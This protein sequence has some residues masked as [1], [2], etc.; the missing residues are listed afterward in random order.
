MTGRFHMNK[1]FS[2]FFFENDSFWWRFGLSC[3]FITLALGLVL[4]LIYTG[5]HVPFLTTLD[6]RRSH[7]HLG[8]YGV[9]FPLIWSLLGRERLWVPRKKWAWAYVLAVAISVIGFAIEG[10]GISAHL[11][12]AVVLIF[13]ITF[14]IKNFHSFPLKNNWLSLIPTSLF[15]ATACVF[16]VGF[17][18]SQ[19]KT[20]ASTQLAR[21]FLTLL[22]FGVVIPVAIG[23]VCP[24][25]RF[26]KFWP[27]A[28]IGMAVFVSELLPPL[29]FF[30][31][32]L[33]LGGIILI[34]LFSSLSEAKIYS[35]LR[36]KL[37]WFL[38][39]LSLIVFSIG[40]IRNSHYG[41][42]AGVHFLVL[43][44]ILMSFVSLKGKLTRFSYDLSLAFM[45]ISI[46]A[47]EFYVADFILLQKIALL[48]GVVV[49]AILATAA[50][51]SFLRNSPD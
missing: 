43:G 45:V 38:V 1:N 39:G 9:L 28:L 42:V 4:R 34:N 18:A 15:A 17:F 14:A 35:L 5:F 46:L 21:S 19:G 50:P 48:S 3:L 36:L 30:W 16:L 32:P 44:P 23:K 41:S 25:A 6:L 7:S 11:A 20:Q 27:A 22:S 24:S 2:K 49:V 37:Y 31:G 8:F 13:W 10:Y 51:A 47:M 33:I 26:L 29:Y 12:S 40:T